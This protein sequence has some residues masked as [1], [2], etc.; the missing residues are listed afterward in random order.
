MKRPY[1]AAAILFV[2]ASWVSVGIAQNLQTLKS[3]IRQRRDDEPLLRELVAYRDTIPDN[4]N[5]EVDYMIAVTLGVL[6]AF[7]DTACDYFKSVQY[8]Y[9][10]PYTFDNRQVNLAAD[11]QKYCPPPPPSG[12]GVQTI[13]ALKVPVKGAALN[14]VKKRLT[15]TGTA[16]G[17]GARSFVAANRFTATDGVYSMVHDGWKGELVLKGQSGTY[18]GSDGRKLPVKVVT[19]SGYHMV[20]IVVGL[21]G[22]NAD[23]LGGQKFDG[24]QM[25][26][27]R[28][29]IAGVTWWQG[30]PF[31]FYAIKR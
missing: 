6:P 30:Q 1:L 10:P 17:R 4:S 8:F 27:T 25:T 21:G 7:R 18:V 29:A 3:F 15:N 5:F 28:D 11:A 16:V 2:L 24:Y 19:A 23:G 31:G 20:F 12:P 26:Q 22:E 9:H 14:E 13:F